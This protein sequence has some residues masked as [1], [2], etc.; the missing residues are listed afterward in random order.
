MASMMGRL[1]SELAYLTGSIRILRRASPIARNPGRTMND[2]I[3]AAARLHADRPALIGD[4]T[5]LTYREMDERI[6]RYARWARSEGIGKGDVVALLMHNSPDYLCFW[7]GLARIG[8]VTALLNTNL[9]GQA[10]AHCIAIVEPKLAVAGAALV[11]AFD[12]AVPFL[13]TSPPLYVHGADVPGRRR[14]EPLVDAQDGSPLGPGETVAVTIE[15]RCIYIYT[16]GTTGWPKAANI[17]HYR[18][19][20]MGM[21]FSALMDTGPADRMYDCLPMYH[22]NGGCLATLGVLTQGGS[23]VI[24]ERFSAREFWPDIVR[25]GCTLFFYIGELCR[26]LVNAPVGPH[27]RSH[28][29][30][31]VCGNGLRPDVWPLFVERF[32]IREIREFYASTE[33]NV[34]LFNLDSREG[35]VGRIPK[36]AEKRFVVEV[37]RF[38]VEKEE[39]V[40]GPDGYC[41]R[42]MPGEAGEVIGQIL[43][44]PAKPANRFEGYADKAATRTKILHDVFEKGDA[45]FRSGDLM[46][47]D[48]DGYFFFVDRIGDTF[49][50]KGENV[51]TSEVSETMTAFP[52]ISECTAYGVRIDG[53]DGKAGMAAL[54]SPD[55][56]GI[57]LKA[58]KAHIDRNLPDYARPVFLRFR[59]TLEVTGT[60]KQRKIDL[61]AQGFDPDATQDPIFFDDPRSG[62]FVRLDADRARELKSGGVRL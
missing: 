22:S 8:G 3:A 2:V 56:A 13:G 53:M 11:D 20:A 27:D 32:G 14:L 18:I 59:D 15:D 25:N 19:M 12:S 1:R 52:G 55:A 33:G 42:C 24:R 4:G 38:D 37:V 28:S 40:R 23:V 62:G 48:A 54:V 29:I 39:P 57:D 7:L 16:S 10:L 26:Y 61:V 34:V 60:F 50:W 46:R 21:G 58:L 36:W 30:R 41:Q 17:N 51:A 45:W 47:R 44:D 9:T 6:V 43:N 31:L 5:T 49:R 35:S